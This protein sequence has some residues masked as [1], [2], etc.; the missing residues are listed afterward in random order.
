MLPG[1]MSVEQFFSP[2]PKDTPLPPFSWKPPPPKRPKRGPGH[3]RRK[4]PPVTVTI[5][6]GNKENDPA[7]TQVPILTVLWGWTGVR[8]SLK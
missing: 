5:D 6:D 8:P 3:P 2:L 7:R 1:K 4:S